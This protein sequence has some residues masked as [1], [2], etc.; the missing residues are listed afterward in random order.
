MSKSRE[1]NNLSAPT[2]PLHSTLFVYRV[3]L[4][5]T[6]HVLFKFSKDLKN[7]QKFQLSRFTKKNPTMTQIHS[8]KKNV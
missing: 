8:D 2:V 3:F 1:N 6:F 4:L 5:H 7:S